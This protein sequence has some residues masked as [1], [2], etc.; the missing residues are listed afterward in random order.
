MREKKKSQ[1]ESTSQADEG[2]KEE[3]VASQTKEPST[4]TQ[5]TTPTLLE[6]MKSAF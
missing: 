3:A 2:S 6:K 5:K 4:A 1:E